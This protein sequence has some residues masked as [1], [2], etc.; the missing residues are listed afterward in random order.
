MYILTLWVKHFILLL[1]LQ[2]WNLTSSIPGLFVV[3][4]NFS[5]LAYEIELSVETLLLNFLLKFFFRLLDE[6]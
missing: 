6:L 1:V 4:F 2:I 5:L 3:W